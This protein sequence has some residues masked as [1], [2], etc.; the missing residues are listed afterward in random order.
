MSIESRDFSLFEFGVYDNVSGEY[1]IFT[2][3]GTNQFLALWTN[4]KG[5]PLPPKDRDDLVK[6]VVRRWNQQP[7]ID[8]LVR[9]ARAALYM[10]PMSQPEFLELERALTPWYAEE[11]EKIRAKAAEK[12]KERGYA[13]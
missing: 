3:T 4:P 12:R 1:G 9:A 5:N 8:T 11:K 6:E 7:Q 2:N 13:S 10:V